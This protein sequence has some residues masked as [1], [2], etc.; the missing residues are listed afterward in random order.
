MVNDI[1]K[2]R[3]EIQKH[4]PEG[5]VRYVLVLKV[6]SAITAPSLREE[7]KVAVKKVLS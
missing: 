2:K 4:L 5:K 6:Y 1:L 3:I 7:P